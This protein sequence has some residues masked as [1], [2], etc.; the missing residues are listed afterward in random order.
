MK[1]RHLKMRKQQCSRPAQLFQ[2]SGR[3][4]AG[5]EDRKQKGPLRGEDVH[6]L[7]GTG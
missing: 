5:L 6:V 4:Q 2:R 7:G 3:K 1:E